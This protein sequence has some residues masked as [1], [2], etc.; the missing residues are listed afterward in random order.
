M[1]ITILR[2]IPNIGNIKL[3]N[4]SST[5]MLSYPKEKRRKK[6]NATLCDIINLSRSQFEREWCA[7]LTQQ[8]L[9][10]TLE[11]NETQQMCRKSCLKDIDFSWYSTE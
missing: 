11:K 1:L 8:G 6:T 9:D 2:N 3:S 5:L 4:S 7:T 10:T